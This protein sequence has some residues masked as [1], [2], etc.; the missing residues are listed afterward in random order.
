MNLKKI[1]TM[2]LR[3]IT[4]L[5]FIAIGIGIFI[6]MSLDIHI[7]LIDFFYSDKIND[8]NKNDLWDGF[9]VPFFI[10]SFFSLIG[11][12]FISLSKK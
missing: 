11:V 3:I 9:A 8:S 1:T 12:L 5:L 10:F 4:G 6:K 7:P 2:I